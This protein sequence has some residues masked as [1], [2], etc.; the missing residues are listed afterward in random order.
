ML[1]CHY[2][3]IRSLFRVVSAWAGRR[4]RAAPET[5][6]TS[7]DQSRMGAKRE[8]LKAGQGSQRGGGRDRC[9]SSEGVRSQTPK[10]EGSRG[11]RRTEMGQELE[12]ER[13]EKLRSGGSLPESPCSETHAGVETCFKS[14]SLPEA[15][16]RPVRA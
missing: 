4:M 7:Q 9:A 14:R 2:V 15:R 5:S 8:A 16:L 10:R 13:A 11:A 12:R 6:W 1:W 3:A